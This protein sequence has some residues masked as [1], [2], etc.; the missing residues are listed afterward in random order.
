VASGLLQVKVIMLSGAVD[1]LFINRRAVRSRLIGVVIGGMS[2]CARDG[3]R[4]A[5]LEA[6]AETA[7]RAWLE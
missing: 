6:V 4:R 2:A 5:E 3:A 1:G 7:M